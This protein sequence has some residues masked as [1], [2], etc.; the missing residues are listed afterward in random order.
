MEHLGAPGGTP[1]AGNMSAGFVPNTPMGAEFAL[2]LG[3][4]FDDVL[5]LPGQSDVLPHEAE[6]LHR[7]TCSVTL[8][9]PRVSA[10]IDPVT[11]ARM[12]IARPRLGGIGIP[13]RT[14]S[15]QE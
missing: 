7:L 13:H 3:L 9:M 11:E 1:A 15:P 2:P 12:A 8:S 14:L 6:A 5:L 4:T 10:G